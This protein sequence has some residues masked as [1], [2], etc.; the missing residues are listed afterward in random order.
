MFHPLRSI[1]T[2]GLYLVPASLLAMAG[3]LLI[4]LLY[5]PAPNHHRAPAAIV[6][7]APHINPVEAMMALWLAEVVRQHKAEQQSQ[8]RI[9][10]HYSTEGGW[11]TGEAVRLYLA[12]RWITPGDDSRRPP[13]IRL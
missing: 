12:P 9:L 1:R 4:A 5:Y 7:D 10:M 2:F 3:A 6:K 11:S 8:A 13:L